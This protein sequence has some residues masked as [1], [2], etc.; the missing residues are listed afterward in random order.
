MYVMKGYQLDW[1][2]Q[3]RLS[4]PRWLHTGELASQVSAHEVGCLSFSSLV[5]RL[6]KKSWKTSSLQFILESQHAAFYSLGRIVVAATAAAMEYMHFPTGSEGEQAKVTLFPP[7]TFSYLGYHW[8]VLPSLSECL[9]PVSHFYK[10]C[11]G[12]IQRHVFQLITDPS[13]IK[14]IYE[15]FR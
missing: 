13:T 9:A 10:Y 12:P 7:Q 14:I 3:Q 1:P 11:Y 15:I 5:L 4:R 8:K 2:A 6:L